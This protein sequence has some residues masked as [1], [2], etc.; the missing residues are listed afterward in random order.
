LLCVDVDGDEYTDVYAENSDV[1]GFWC[2][3]LNEEGTSWHIVRD[4]A[5]LRPTWHATTQ[6]YKLG[7]LTGDGIPEIIVSTGK[8]D[9]TGGPTYLE[10]PGNPEADPWPQHLV[11]HD[12]NEEGIAV[13]DFDNDGDN[14]IA[15]A[16]AGSNFMYWFENKGNFQWAKHDVGPC[17]KVDW[18]GSDRVEP[19]DF[20]QDGNMDIMNTTE[21]SLTAVVRLFH[22]EGDAAD[23]SFEDIFQGKS[24]NNADVADMDRDGDMDIV[25]AEHLPQD[26]PH[27]VIVLENDNK[28]ENWIQHVVDNQG[29]EGHLGARLWDLDGDGDFEIVNTA[30]YSIKYVH[31]W[32]NNAC[33][34][35][36]PCGPCPQQPPV[37]VRSTPQ[38]ESLSS[39]ARAMRIGGG[40]D[41]NLGGELAGAK[42]VTVHG[43][44]GRFVAAVAVC[45]GRAQWDGRD[46]SGRAAPAGT[47]VYRIGSGAASDAG[48]FVVSR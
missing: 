34:P 24:L 36:N 16:K 20:D 4:V 15:N 42:R 22:N 11:D 2:E 30:F 41:F 19:I 37:Q 45:Q 1:K 29:R 40:I 9:L 25:I 27:R 13:A 39:G 47:Y 14:D 8:E 26:D 32:I 48:T 5:S 17:S 7:D 33:S 21:T 12:G 3:A 23:W 46:R 44:D 18:G 6:G 28:G 35:D 31:L 38:R 10:I 43:V